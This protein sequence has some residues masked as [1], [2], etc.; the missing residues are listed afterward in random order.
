MNGLSYKKCV[1]HV[2]TPASKDF[3][4]AGGSVPTPREFL[5]MA[6][7]NG[8]EV[9]GICD[10]HSID[11][12]KPLRDARDEIFRET[13]K[14]ITIFPGIELH[15]PD[16][17]H[18]LVLFDPEKKIEDIETFIGALEIAKTDRGREDYQLK[19]HGLERGALLKL[20]NEYQGLP[21]LA[22]AHQESKGFF[23]ACKGHKVKE[24]IMARGGIIYEVLQ[25]K[26]SEVYKTCKNT[27]CFCQSDIHELNDF[28]KQEIAFWVQMA[29][30]PTLNSLKQVLFEP[31]RIS[32]DEPRLPEYPRIIRLETQTNYFGS[33]NLSFNDELNVFIGGRGT[34]KSLVIEIITFILCMYPMTD[35]DLK[36]NYFD[37][38]NLHL[39]D[40][41]PS[42]IYISKGIEQYRISRDFVPFEPKTKG[43]KDYHA[44]LKQYDKDN[45][46]VFEKYENTISQWSEELGQD[47]KQIIPI[48]I[49]TQKC[50]PDIAQRIDLLLEIID[51]QSESLD[52]SIG[53][54]IKKNTA[55]A[56]N[57]EI[58]KLEEELVKKY[59]VLEN[60][61]EIE[62]KINEIKIQIDALEATLGSEE[63]KKAI[64]W[65][66]QDSKCNSFFVD[67]TL[68]LDSLPNYE[69][70]VKE[71]P[72]LERVDGFTEFDFKKI[73]QFK[74]DTSDKIKSLQ[75]DR[76]SFYSNTLSQKVLL[77]SEWKDA[78]RQFQTTHSNLS[79]DDGQES[80]ENR[81]SA[82]KKTLGTM[83]DKQ[84][85]N[86]ALIEDIKKDETS[87]IKKIDSL[88]DLNDEI[89]TSRKRICDVI[90]SR[91]P[92]PG[93]SIKLFEKGNIDEI[94]TVLLRIFQSA[95]FSNKQVVFE[96]LASNFELNE[97]YGLITCK[98]AISDTILTRLKN[99]KIPKHMVDKFQNHTIQ[100]SKHDFSIAGLGMVD[101]IEI[102]TLQHTFPSN[103]VTIEYKKGN[104]WKDISTLSPGEKCALIL[105]VLLVVDEKILIIDQ[106]EDELDYTSRKDLIDILINKK[107]KRQIIL[108][109]HFQNIP[110]LADA[111]LIVKTDEV[112]NH[113]VIPNQGCFEEMINPILELEGGPEAFKKRAEKYENSL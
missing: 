58:M 76:D 7:K 66:D 12:I 49:F 69:V 5:E 33:L 54:I 20:I 35:P 9:L 55:Q 106:P 113:G 43:E 79:I 40:G 77:E 32:F 47:W 11:W 19:K 98:E 72:V 86:N 34:G 81:I 107:K 73:E 10:H 46:P 14:E 102:L 85:N 108:V 8:I 88:K 15:T 92:L 100:S 45:P 37:K 1:L 97:L 25:S 90:Q 60:P 36:K 6:L 51:S 105:R 111:N 82:L 44:F 61:A 64:K 59:G 91:F 13:Q 3:K 71:I 48:D 38:L 16:S 50:V 42:T 63:R 27:A 62:Q 93:T 112:D 103:T 99:A 21:V 28:N 41:E 78:F 84:K 74:K 18:V 80:L 67:I 94:I 101:S 95:S 75:A 96:A 87:R 52:P 53:L 4:S 104:N 2:H 23:K 26:V 24:D 39:I 89:F 65:R 70:G 22:H 30:K 17:V 110:V 56:L 31:G 68:L 109:T 83:I 57:L 29:P